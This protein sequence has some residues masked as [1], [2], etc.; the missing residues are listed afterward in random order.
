MSEQAITLRP[1]G[2]IR[3][4]FRE[5]AGTPI[6]GALADTCGTV[7]VAPEFEAGLTG[8]EGF[9]HLIL[10]YAF[11]R[12]RAD[13]PLIQKPYLE[14]TERGVFAIRS[15]LRPNPIGFTVVRL[16]ERQ[17]RVLRVR[18]VDML[19]AT[20]LLDIKPYVARFDAHPEASAGWLEP[21]LERAGRHK[22]DGR[23]H[24]G[25]GEEGGAK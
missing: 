2:L 9:S 16:L 13:V 6:Q 10:L 3:T 8:I 19:D 22:A 17:G 14:E 7:E 18:G 1:I 11:H 24:G 5:P 23:F 20:P 4:P 21:H 15:P 25:G 12:S